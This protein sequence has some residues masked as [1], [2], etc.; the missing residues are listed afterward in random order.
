MPVTL[1]ERQFQLPPIPRV[2]VF[3]VQ[4]MGKTLH[5]EARGEPSDGLTACGWSIR[6]RVT[7]ARRRWPRDVANACLQWRQFSAWNPGDPNRSLLIEVELGDPDYMRCLAVAG[8]VI[9][10]L[11]PDLSNGANHYLT[12][13]V[14]EQSPPDWFSE[15]KITARYGRHLFLRL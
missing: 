6:N 4:V 9:A 11:V 3:D 8:N 15:A 13:A 12:K 7:D 2:D 1:L 10:G 5:G 14:A